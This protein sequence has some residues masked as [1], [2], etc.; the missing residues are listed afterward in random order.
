ME[1]FS[2]RWNFSGGAGGARANRPLRPRTPALHRIITALGVDPQNAG[3]VAGHR[4]TADAFRQDGQR[5]ASFRTY[6]PGGARM[7]ASA[8]LVERDRLLIGADPKGIYEFPRPAKPS[9]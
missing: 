5:L 7:E 4:H 8:I 9:Q 2:R 1:I 3:G 6:M